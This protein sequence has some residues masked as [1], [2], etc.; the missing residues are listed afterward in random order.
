VLTVDDDI[1]QLLGPEVFLGVDGHTGEDGRLTVSAV[2]MNRE[3]LYAAVQCGGTDGLLRWLQRPAR[4]QHVSI[5]GIAV[6][7]TRAGALIA[8]DLEG[9]A[10]PVTRYDVREMA[11]ASHGFHVDLADHRFKCAQKPSRKDALDE[12]VAL[13]RRKPLGDDTS[14]RFVYTTYLRSNDIAPLI[15]LV[16]ANALAA[17]PVAELFAVWD[18]PI[19]SQPDIQRVGGYTFPTWSTRDQ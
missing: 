3:R 11:A 8:R 16:L 6:D 12:A 1:D 17:M 10:F 13:A 19:G 7:V 18:S 5:L 14:E 9:A 2:A 15:A 4:R